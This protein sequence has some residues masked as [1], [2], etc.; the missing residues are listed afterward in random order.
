MR[1]RQ[2]CIIF[3]RVSYRKVR[4]HKPFFN[5]APSFVQ[6]RS[7]APLRTT[8]YA[9]PIVRTDP[10]QRAAEQSRRISRSLSEKLLFLLFFFL[11]CQQNHCDVLPTHGRFLVRQEKDRTSSRTPPDKSRGEYVE[12]QRAPF[13]RR[14]R[15]R[16]RGGK[17]CS[18]RVF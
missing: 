18:R 5:G 6:I 1:K 15:L 7:R 13:A 4:C 12:R 9:Y 17:D 8:L 10:L 3:H 14:S 2:K 16:S 11:N